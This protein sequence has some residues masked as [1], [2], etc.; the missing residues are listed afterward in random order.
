MSSI[1]FNRNC[2]TERTGAGREQGNRPVQIANKEN[3]WFLPQ[4]AQVP[5]APDSGRPSTPARDAAFCTLP[6]QGESSDPFPVGVLAPGAVSGG[7]RGGDGTVRDPGSLARPMSGA[8]G[9]RA[10]RAEI[11]VEGP[12]HAKCTG[13]GWRWGPLCASESV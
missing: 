1:T 10:C 6:G 11:R 7:W 8:E 4:P 2:L 13:P 5:V 12:H 3:D 9:R